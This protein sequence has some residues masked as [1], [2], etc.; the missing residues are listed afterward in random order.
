MFRRC[1]PG[2]GQNKRKKVAECKQMMKT[3]AFWAMAALVIT[4]CNSTHDFFIR[5][6]DVEGLKKSDS[7][8]FGNKPI[9]AVRDVEYTDAGDFLVK[10][11]VDRDFADLPRDSSTFYI[12]SNPEA[13]GRK[14]VIIV[15][16]REGGSKIEQDAIVQGQSKYAALFGRIAGEFRNHVRMLESGIDE[17]FEGLKD[18]SADEQIKRIEAELDKLIAQMENLSAEMKN[19]LENEVL[20]RIRER[21]EELRRRLEQMGKEEKLKYVDRKMKTISSRL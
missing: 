19:R 10:A 16:I 12:D 1:A 4:G 15:Q 3:L 18:F 21:I 17:F 7:I 11:A 2:G 9:G 14:A 20:P 8:I 5:F 13:E 6:N